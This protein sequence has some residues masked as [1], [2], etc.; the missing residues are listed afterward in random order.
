M[1]EPW[2][3]RTRVFKEHK[4]F[5]YESEAKLRIDNKTGIPFPSE[6]RTR[7]KELFSETA[8]ELHNKVAKIFD[9]YKPRCG[10]LRVCDGALAVSING[11]GC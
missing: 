10:T 3:E 4:V 6:I 11:G 1:I 2:A 8:D 7:I 5:S 9:D